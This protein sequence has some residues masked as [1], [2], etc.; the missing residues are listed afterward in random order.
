[1]S[2]KKKLQPET[3]PETEVAKAPK[4]APK[5]TKKDA[6]LDEYLE[7]AQ[8]PVAPAP[9]PEVVAVSPI[10]AQPLATDQQLAVD[11]RSKDMQRQRLAL[12]YREEE[13]VAVT[14]APAYR[15]QLGSTAMISVNG[16]SVHI[17]CNGRPYKIN[18]THAAEVF[19]TLSRID[20]QT[21]RQGL[22]ADVKSNDEGFP[23][24]LSF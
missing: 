2:T 8:I 13:Q 24:E 18:A 6:A 16:I 9:V 17:P 3:A 12:F 11:Y 23:G 4:K 22:M 19:E 14:I 21:M 1:M 15:A 5:T 20:K 10:T 7:T